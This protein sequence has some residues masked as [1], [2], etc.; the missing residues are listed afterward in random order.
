MRALILGAA[1]AAALFQGADRPLVDD[2]EM[3][4]GCADSALSQKAQGI[5]RIRPAC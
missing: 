1:I 3:Y 2:F 4:R 5:E